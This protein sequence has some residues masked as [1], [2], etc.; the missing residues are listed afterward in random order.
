MRSMRMNERTAHCW[1]SLAVNMASDHFYMKWFYIRVMT[2]TTTTSS[3][4]IRYCF[5]WSACLSAYLSLP[6]VNGF[7][8]NLFSS[9]FCASLATEWQILWY[10][11]LCVGL[12]GRG[13]ERKWWCIMAVVSCE[14]VYESTSGMYFVLTTKNEAIAIERDVMMQVYENDDKSSG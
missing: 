12:C 9:F 2:T 11:V 5:I 1:F 4:M 13:S 7:R 8:R 10:D 3:T 14:Y 6:L